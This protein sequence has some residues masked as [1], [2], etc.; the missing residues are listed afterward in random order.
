MPT[1]INK[2]TLEHLAEL[3]RMELK[4]KNE[5]KLLEDLRKI[6]EHFGELEGLDTK[7][8][9][10]VAGGTAVENVFRE[11]GADCKLRAEN[12]K[13]TGAFP[14]KENGYLKV[15]PVFAP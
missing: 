15:P 12:G 10:P 4:G 9:E 7:N 13:L 8:V 3:S 2:K 14:E 1:L 11:D 6:L 5:E